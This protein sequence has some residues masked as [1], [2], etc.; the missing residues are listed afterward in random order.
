MSSPIDQVED[1]DPALRYAPR[2]ARDRGSPLPDALFRRPRQGRCEERVPNS[3]AIAPWSSCSA[4][5]FSIPT[6]FRSRPRTTRALCADRAALFG[7][8]G[9]CRTHCLGRRSN[10][11]HEEG[12]RHIP[13]V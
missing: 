2:W 8:D 4:S 12:Q 5:S 13:A 3:A 9:T 10:S 6:L 7:G 11:R 1:L